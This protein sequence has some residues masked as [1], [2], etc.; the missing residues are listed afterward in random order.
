MAP[1][2]LRVAAVIRS[3]LETIAMEDYKGSVAR[4]REEARISH[5]ISS[6]GRPRETRVGPAHSASSQRRE[7]VGYSCSALGGELE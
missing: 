4:G 3:K 6:Y 2:L 5:A 7:W 1:I